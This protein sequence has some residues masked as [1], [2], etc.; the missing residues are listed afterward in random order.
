MNYHRGV[1]REKPCLEIK[2][3]VEWSA[4]CAS[5]GILIAWPRT[6]RWERKPRISGWVG[7]DREASGAGCYQ[8]QILAP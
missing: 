6:G 7:I 1:S 8:V 5:L 4:L 3:A 2:D